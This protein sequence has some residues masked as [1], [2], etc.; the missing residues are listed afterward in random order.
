MPKNFKN[1]VESLAAKNS[2]TDAVTTADISL[3]VRAYD[4]AGLVLLLPSL[5]CAE[6]RRNVL[7]GAAPCLQLPSGS[8]N[9]FAAGQITARKPNQPDPEAGS[10]RVRASE[11]LLTQD[12]YEIEP[13]WACRVEPG[14]DV[15]DV[16]PRT[17]AA[18]F[19][20]VSPPDVPLGRSDGLFPP[21]PA[22]RRRPA[23]LSIGDRV[24]L[25]RAYV[26]ISTDLGGSLGSSGP[27][28]MVSCKSPLRT[29]FDARAQLARPRTRR[30]IYSRRYYASPERS[31]VY[32]A[33]QCDWSETAILCSV[34]CRFFLAYEHS[35]YASG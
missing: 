12:A 29:K 27:F 30:S 20:S 9:G 4:H 8:H 22:P 5:R 33:L 16:L 35:L 23:G 13:G 6:R 11:I 10:R 32:R 7:P 21:R 3:T 14:S 17:G 34:V 2:P 26:D 15:G 24:S 25:D 18:S 31:R 19:L 28:A 1:R